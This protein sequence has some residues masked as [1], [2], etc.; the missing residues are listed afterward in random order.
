MKKTICQK[1]LANNTFNR[2]KLGAFLL[3]LR[4]LVLPLLLLNMVPEHL[5]QHEMRKRITKYKEQ[6]I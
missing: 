5:Q 6:I 4:K 1:P 2:K 3:E